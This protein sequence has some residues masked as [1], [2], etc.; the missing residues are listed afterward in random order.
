[1]SKSG[2]DDQIGFGRERCHHF[3]GKQLAEDQPSGKLRNAGPNHFTREEG[4]ESSEGTAISSSTC[5]GSWRTV[6]EPRPM[7]QR[8]IPG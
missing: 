4:G 1:M 6:D 3:D 2:G 7:L 5:R 8:R